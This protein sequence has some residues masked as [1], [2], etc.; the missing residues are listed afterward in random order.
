MIKTSKSGFESRA[1]LLLAE[2]ILYLRYLFII[3][4]KHLKNFMSEVAG[5]IPAQFF[6]LLKGDIPNDMESK[7]N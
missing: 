5:S 2:Y 3:G 7:N 1:Y 6:Y 4:E